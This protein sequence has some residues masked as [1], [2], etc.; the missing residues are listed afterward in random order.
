MNRVIVAID[1]VSTSGQ[2][3]KCITWLCWIPLFELRIQVN[4]YEQI[5]CDPCRP[6]M[7]RELPTA[8]R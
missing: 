5:V 4:F 3:M 7:L 8:Q 1:L 6:R 2:Y